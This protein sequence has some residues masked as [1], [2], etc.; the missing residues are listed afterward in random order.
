VAV[1]LTSGTNS[2]HSTAPASALTGRLLV[3]TSSNGWPY[4]L[5]DTH[6]R[7]VAPVHRPDL[8][9]C[10]AVVLAP[11]GAHLVLQE[12]NAL[13]VQPVG[14]AA[15]PL[16]PQTVLDVATIA[17][18]PDSRRIAFS[19]LVGATEP[20]AADVD[21]VNADGSALRVVAHGVDVHSIAWSPDGTQLAFAQNQGGIRVVSSTGGRLRQILPASELAR[22]LP[23]HLSWAPA[24]RLLF[25]QVGVVPDGVWQID[26]DG[27]ALRAVLPSATNPSWA[28]DG[29]HFAAIRGKRVVIADPAGQV[30]RTIGPNGAV[31]VQWGG[32]G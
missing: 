31:S 13:L 1:V 8:L 7:V 32:S 19:T 12:E 30:V 21:V 16:L 4:H 6:G 15:R 28:P 5:L 3:K 25:D 18:S 17:W 11:D 29:E 20:R 22:M 24:N 9:C 10:S 2:S 14:G 23:D 27:S 26:P